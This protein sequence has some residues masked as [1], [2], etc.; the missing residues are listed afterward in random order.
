MLEV[1]KIPSKKIKSF[2]SQYFVQDLSRPKSESQPQPHQIEC[3]EPVK[4]MQ[5]Q[6]DKVKALQY[7]VNYNLY[8][9]SWNVHGRITHTHLAFQQSKTLMKSNWMY[10]NTIVHNAVQGFC[11]AYQ[12]LPNDLRF[13]R[14]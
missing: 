6:F 13:S 4:S 12:Y 14:M 9:V 8:N 7:F 3:P 10:K 1:S 2:C 11:E 5:K